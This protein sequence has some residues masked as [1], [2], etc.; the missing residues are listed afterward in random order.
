MKDLT[1]TLEKFYNGSVDEEKAM[2]KINEANPLEISKAEQKL[3]DRGMTQRE[4][5]EFCE[6]HLQAIQDKIKKI[7]EKLE[8]DHPIKTLINEHEKILDYLNELENLQETLENRELKTN[9]EKRLQ[10]LADHLVDSEKHHDREE[11]VIFPRLE[12]KGI[13]G[14]PRIMRQDHDKFKP[15][16]KELKKL[17]ENPKKNKEE[18]IDIIDFLTLNLKD[19][20]FKEDNILYPTALKKLKDW[21][22][23]KE[24]ANQVGYCQFTPRT[25]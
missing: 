16:K 24:E 21:T 7:K 6:L 22:K 9:E 18:I 23:I 1:E 3:L 25:N 5:R 11:E 10:E 17:A 19:H 2:K 4:L 8:P 14:P 15:K 13:D 12:A 20:I